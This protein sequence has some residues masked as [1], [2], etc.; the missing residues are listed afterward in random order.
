MY[1][2]TFDENHLLGIDLSHFEPNVNWD[3]AKAAGVKW[4]YSKA[5]DGREFVDQTLGMHTGGAARA[6]IPTGAYHFFRGN[7]PT[8]VQVNLFLSTV[9]GKKFSLPYILDWEEAGF[10]GIH[11]SQ[12][13]SEI[14]TILVALKVEM[15]KDPVRA[16]D[17]LLH[18]PWLYTGDEEAAWLNEADFGEYPMIIARYPNPPSLPK[19][20]KLVAHQFTS[21]FSIAGLAEGH[22]CDADVFFGN[23][24]QLKAYC[25]G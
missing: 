23:D 16:A 24:A 8:D 6:G 17:P 1:Q 10:E 5:T 13:V 22:H 11:P 21:G 4:M 3:E 25:A 19:W 20:C 7:V 15:L 18:T 12:M 14:K 9:R 2:P